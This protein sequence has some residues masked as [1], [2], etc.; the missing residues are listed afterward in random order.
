[1]IEEEE[2]G[3]LWLTFSEQCR[4]IQFGAVEVSKSSIMVN[5]ERIIRD[6]EHY[7]DSGIPLSS[8]CRRNIILA[9]VWKMD[10]KGQE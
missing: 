4:M 6:T 10:G 9:P 7:L 5:N 1:M 2:E 3:Q 8:K